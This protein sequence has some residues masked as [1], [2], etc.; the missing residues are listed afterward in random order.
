MTDANPIGLDSPKYIWNQCN[1]NHFTFPAPL[2]GA[3][4][5]PPPIVRLYALG[6]FGAIL[7]GLSLVAHEHP[8]L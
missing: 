5:F 4:R 2:S 8:S 6:R 7:V 3:L 1:E